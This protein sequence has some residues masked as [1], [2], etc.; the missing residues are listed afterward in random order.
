MYKTKEKRHGTWKREFQQ[1]SK[2]G[3]RIEHLR[4]PRQSKGY[5]YKNGLQNSSWGETEQSSLNHD[6]VLCNPAFVLLNEDR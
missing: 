1:K 4:E 6:N 5:R 2:R 3:K